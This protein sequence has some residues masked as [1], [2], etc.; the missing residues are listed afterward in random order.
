MGSVKTLLLTGDEVNVL[1]KS[2]MVIA[3]AKGKGKK[4]KVIPLG[5]SITPTEALRNTAA[6]LHRRMDEQNGGERTFLPWD[7]QEVR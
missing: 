1:V 2:I 3:D 5:V 4:V 7:F 6:W